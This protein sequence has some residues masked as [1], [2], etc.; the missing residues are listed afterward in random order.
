MTQNI[1]AKK[2]YQERTVP[3]IFFFE[4]A[5]LL[6]LN[7]SNDEKGFWQRIKQKCNFEGASCLALNIRWKS[8]SRLYV[9][10]ELSSC[11]LGLVS[12]L[13][14]LLS[15]EKGEMRGSAMRWNQTKIKLCLTKKTRKTD[16]TFCLPLHLIFRK[17]YKGYK[18]ANY[19]APP[20][21]T[22]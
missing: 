21:L 11:A 5:Y 8:T 20:K 13:K 16:V 10:G 2:G 6:R 22:I 15:K 4:R 14:C 1:G 7:R 18:N 17:Y 12:S 9:T 3:E 19:I